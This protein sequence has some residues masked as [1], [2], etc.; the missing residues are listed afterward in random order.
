MNKPLGLKIIAWFLII[1]GG[2]GLLSRL[3]GLASMPIT[4]PMIWH[5]VSSALDIV[6]GIGLLKVKKWAWLGEIV[7]R[8]INAIPGVIYIVLSAN[9]EISATSIVIFILLIVAGAII[10]Y[11]LRKD[12]KKMFKVSV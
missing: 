12:I 8:I 11:L 10:A 5:T 6:F 1:L 4:L 9:R 7:L 3:I 2:L